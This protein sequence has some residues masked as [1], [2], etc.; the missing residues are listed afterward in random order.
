MASH[1]DIDRSTLS[2]VN[3]SI[4]VPVNIDKSQIKWDGNDATILGAASAG[5]DGTIYGAH[6]THS[7]YLHHAGAIS[8]AVVK[9]A[10]EA[11][12]NG[13]DAEMAQML[14]RA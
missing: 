14:R 12:V 2:T 9:S 11:L 1:D 5:R 7:F 3:T 8:M 10:A 4:T 6:S 13:V